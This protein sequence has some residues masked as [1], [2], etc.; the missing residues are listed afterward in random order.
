MGNPYDDFDIYDPWDD[1]EADESGSFEFVEDEYD[2]IDHNEPGPAPE[3]IAP[4]S[5]EVFPRTQVRPNYGEPASDEVLYR[6]RDDAYDQQQN[7]YATNPPRARGYTPAYEPVAPEPEPAPRRRRHR[8]KHHFGCLVPL[9]VFVAAVVGLYMVFLRPIDEKLAF[10]PAEQA[11][12][13]GATSWS[14]PGTPYYV[15]LLGSDAREGEEVSRT[16]T[17][18]LARVDFWGNKLTLVSIPRDTKVEISGYGTNKINAAYAFGGAGGAVRAVTQ[19]TGVPIHH[20][21]V[22]H[23]EELAGLIDYLG[24]VTVNVPE[25][26]SDPYTELE[27]DSGL[28]TMDGQTAVLWA[29]SRYGYEDGDIQRQE[30]QRILLTALMNR[31]LSL[32]P[33][34]FPGLLSQTGDLVGT[35]LRCYDIIPLFARYMLAHPEIY[36]CALPTTSAYE[37]DVWYE[38]TDA[39][40]VTQ[41]MNAVNEGRNPSA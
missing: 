25:A 12:L 14:I 9:L 40:T 2:S 3:P 19:L 7:A 1:D 5:T 38:V 10:S 24:G 37:D 4:G 41:F 32:S 33:F 17:M 13:E 6:R 11:T 36:S 39:A 23:F 16:D 28:Q 35:D 8:R 21:A 29:R 34:E 31:M 15:L 27:L 20:V 26:L 30:D 22:I 18:L